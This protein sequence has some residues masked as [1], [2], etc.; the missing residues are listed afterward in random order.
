[1]NQL[2]Q[3]VIKDS[4]TFFTFENGRVTLAPFT[5][6]NGDITMEIAGSHGFD[7][8][9]QYGMNMMVPRSAMGSQGNALI[10]N[11]TAKAAG[12][13]VPVKVGDKVNLA[14]KIGGTVSKPTIETNL[15]D[16]AGNAVNDIKKQIANEVQKKADS[17][18]NV[19]KD[20]I[21]AV[22]NQVV[23]EAKNE[24]KNA[25]N[26]QLNGTKDTAKKNNAL[27]DAKNKAKDKL[28]GLFK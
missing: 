18:K 26:N 14:I 21:K 19:V 9:I 22:K 11:L 17:V 28:K 4:K 8:S 15:K 16:V 3:I 2:K 6:K 12:S 7:Q 10:D 13:G 5:Y 25:I 23:N 27:E 20:T 1:M 24:V